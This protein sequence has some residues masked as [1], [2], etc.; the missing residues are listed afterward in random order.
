MTLP[1]DDNAAG[2]LH[3]SATRLHRDNSE[4]V[5]GPSSGQYV[6]MLVCMH[7]HV[8]VRPVC[9]VGIQRRCCISQIRFTF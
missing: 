5:T 1:G 9:M 7:T 8:A 4:G 3:D 2:F 6:H